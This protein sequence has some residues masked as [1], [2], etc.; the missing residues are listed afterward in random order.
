MAAPSLRSRA[1]KWSRS[2]IIIV[3]APVPLEP[4]DLNRYTLA[5][6]LWSNALTFTR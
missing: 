3:F 1:R 6:L 2:E 4:P 5:D